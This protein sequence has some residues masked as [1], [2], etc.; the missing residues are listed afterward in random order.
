MRFLWSC[1][2]TGTYKG[3]FYWC[4]SMDL[5]FMNEE[6]AEAEINLEETQVQE[7]E[8]SDTEISNLYL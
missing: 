3:F 5:E 8:S 2:I 4:C 1:N 6:D 7:A